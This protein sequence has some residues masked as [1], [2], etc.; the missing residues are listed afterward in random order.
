MT[1]EQLGVLLF[2][3]MRQINMET[4]GVEADFRDRGLTVDEAL[5]A[6][7]GLRGL[8]DVLGRQSAAL[9]G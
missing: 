2:H 6:V 5:S 7:S 8:A 1:N 3:L 9:R 4:S